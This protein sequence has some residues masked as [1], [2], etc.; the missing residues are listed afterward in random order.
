MITRDESSLLS[1]RTSYYIIFIS[2]MVKKMKYVYQYKLDFYDDLL[3]II[4]EQVE[5]GNNVIV[6][7]DWNT[8]HR[9]IDLPVL[10]II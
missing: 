2:Q 5:S 7:G 10:K 4:N 8:A 1:M 6:T 9:P 3:P